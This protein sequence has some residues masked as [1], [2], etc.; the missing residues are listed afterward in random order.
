MMVTGP[1]NPFVCTLS[2]CLYAR[3]TQHPAAQRTPLWGYAA[4]RSS[5]AGQRLTSLALAATL[6]KVNHTSDQINPVAS[7]STQGHQ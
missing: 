5:C 2:A 4:G 6:T 3:L 7:S 1:D